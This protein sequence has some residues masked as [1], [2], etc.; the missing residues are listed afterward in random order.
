M[1]SEQLDTMACKIPLK[2]YIKFQRKGVKDLYSLIKSPQNIKLAYRR[3]KANSGSKTSGVDKQTIQHFKQMSEEEFVN[4]IQEKLENYQPSEVKRVYIPKPN[5]KQR[6]LGI[7]TMEDRICQQAIRQVIEPICEAKFNKHS[8]GFRPLEGCE[9]AL[10]DVYQ[11]ISISHYYW[12]LSLDIKGFFDNVNHRRLRQALWGIGIQDTRVLQIIMKML[13][14]DIKEPD[15]KIGKAEKGTPQGGI[16]SPLLANVYLNCLDQWLADQWENFDAHMTKPLKKRYN[17]N[18]ERK[19]GNEFRALRKSRLKEFA[20]VRYADD[21]VILCASLQNAKKLKLAIQDFLINDLK[22]EISEE[23][24]KIVNLKKGHIKYLGFEIG[25]QLKDN[26]YVVEAHMSQ[27]AI[28]KEKNKLVEQVKKIQ[29]PP[30][31]IPRWGLINQY[32]SMVM[33]IHNYYRKA[34]HINLDLNK[35]GYELNK[36]IENRLHPTRK[37]K[38]EQKGLQKYSESDQ[39]RYLENVPI[40][41]LRYVQTTKPMSRAS[42]A[43]IYTPEGVEWIQQYMNPPILLI[44]M[45]MLKHPIRNRSMEYNDNRISL[46][47]GQ[48]GKDKITGE[49]LR[50]DWIDCHHIKPISQGGDDSYRNLILVD[51]A[52]HELIHMTEKEDIEG[53]LLDLQLDK[54]QIKKLNKYR[55]LVGNFE[56]KL[57]K[58]ENS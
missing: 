18:G 7:P 3:I 34:T 28:K 54:E 24:T 14:A 43:N 48:Y 36:I 30:A 17:K 42:K 6:P 27:E 29:R 57:D 31:N 32:N 9:S 8:H 13:K 49:L 11:R 40:L 55:K 1:P 39:V 19:M 53:Y 12:A 38:I 25:T 5:G 45:Y 21:V 44:Q 58:G 22:L 23:K 2:S 4:Y 33:G 26:K 37:G 50:E 56:I 46:V 35:I 41:P 52:I 51:S 10:A 20:F 47:S 15:G 16:I